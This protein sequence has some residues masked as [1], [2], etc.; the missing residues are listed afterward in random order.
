M[1][2]FTSCS[3]F[4]ILPLI[5]LLCLGAVA[6]QR[7]DTAVKNELALEV[8]NLGAGP[9]EIPAFH[10]GGGGAVSPLLMLCLGLAQALRL[11]R[12]KPVG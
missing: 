1:K 4:K 6:Q 5:V 12:G 2:Q 10:G 3:W 9:W 11:R 8:S 7:Q